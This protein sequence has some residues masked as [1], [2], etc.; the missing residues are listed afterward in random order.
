MA[1]SQF[2]LVVEKYVR[3][4]IAQE[5][6]QAFRAAPVRLLD[7]GA[8]DCDAVS[9]DDKILGCICTNAGLTISGR[10]AAPKLH[11]V[12][13]DILFLLRAHADR[14]MIVLTDKAMYDLC[15]RQALA[16]RMPAE[17]EFTF[18]PVPQAMQAQLRRSHEQAAREVTPATP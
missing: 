7:G 18:V 12:R 15:R 1:N 13:S 5:L 11:K 8:F 9:A 17:I 6:G 3:A 10:C 14:R 4:N 2:R 16:G